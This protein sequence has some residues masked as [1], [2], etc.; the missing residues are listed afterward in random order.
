M[1]EESLAGSSKAFSCSLCW[2]KTVPA[3]KGSQL[4]GEHPGSWEAWRGK[5]ASPWR[6]PPGNAPWGERAGTSPVAQRERSC[7]SPA[8]GEKAHFPAARSWPA[9]PPGAETKSF[10]CIQWDVEG[11]RQRGR[12]DPQTVAPPRPDGAGCGI[13]SEKLFFYISKTNSQ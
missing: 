7:F 6:V 12:R 11:R 8:K 13:Y 5:G 10:G 4:R 3:A 9:K 2:R 1:L